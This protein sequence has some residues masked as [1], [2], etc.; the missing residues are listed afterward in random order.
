MDRIFDHHPALGGERHPVASIPARHHTVEHVETG[1]HKAH[2]L[3]RRSDAHQVTRLRLGQKF[4]GVGA[5]RQSLSPALA[6]RQSA[7][8]IAVESDFLQFCGTL[9]SHIA[10][11][12]A[13][14]NT[15]LELARATMGLAGA[16]GPLGGPPQCA[17]HVFFGSP[18]R[19]TFVQNHG[20]VDAQFLLIRDHIFGPE[21]PA[22]AVDMALEED[23][24]VGHRAHAL[25]TEDLKPTRVRQNRAI[26]THERMQAAHRLD[27][28][29]PRAHGEMVGI[30]E[31][32]LG[33]HIP[34]F[35]GREPFDSSVGAHRH[36][37]GCL[38]GPMRCHQKTAAGSGARIVRR[39]PK[40][41]G[42]RSHVFRCAAL[43]H[44]GLS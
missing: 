21:E 11:Q 19:R 26:P 44:P 4:Y 16:S 23:A 9:G 28:I 2:Q 38:H 32:Q 12:P 15:E 31:D 1:G 5:D 34:Q 36:E 33:A 8:R 43:V 7:H 42:R 14:N 3:L 13:L 22:A 10:V 41:V 18:G 25:E 39:D 17:G 37:R 35:P 27:R 20:D 30:G 24:L 6:Y 40:C 29:G